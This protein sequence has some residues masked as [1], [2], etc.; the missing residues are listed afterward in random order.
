MW[1]CGLVQSHDHSH[2]VFAVEDGRRQNI[3]G[4]VVCEFIDEGAEVL[5]LED[6]K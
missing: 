4:L 1:P 6:R 2:Q 5:V 3:S